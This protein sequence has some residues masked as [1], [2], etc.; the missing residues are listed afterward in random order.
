VLV[1]QEVKS[2]I[3]SIECAKEDYR[4]IVNPETSELDAKAT[5]QLREEIE[6]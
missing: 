6:S 1:A 3:I 4:V 2:G 5:S